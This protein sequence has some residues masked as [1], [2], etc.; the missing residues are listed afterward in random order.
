MKVVL[1]NTYDIQ[2]GAA[3]ATYRL[4]KGLRKYGVKSKLLVQYKRS[5]DFTV[6]GTQG[7]VER[8]LSYF[9]PYLDALVNRVYRNKKREL[10]SA[11]LVPDFLAKKITKLN[12]QIVHLFWVAGGFF[13]VETLKNIQVP[14]VWTL[15]DMWPFTGGCHYDDECGKFKNH[16]GNCPILNSGKDKDLS[17]LVLKRKLEAWDQVPIV[18]VATSYW[19]ADMAKASSVFKDKRVVVIPNGIDTDKYKPIDKAVSRQTWG[20]PLD[21]NL[22]L[23]SA[24]S[25]TSDKRKG[26]QFLVPALESMAREG[27]GENTELVIIGASEPEHPANLGMKV[28]YIGNLGDEISQILLYSAVDVTVAPSMQENLSNTVMESLACGAPVVA[29]NV[30]G[31]PDLIDHMSTGYLARPFEVDD[32]AAGIKWVVEDKNRHGLLSQAARKSVLEKYALEKVSN[33]YIDLYQDILK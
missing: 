17:H 32:L 5:D 33:Q 30:G 28:H 26:N 24:F 31:M 6:V 19:L 9:R 13:R 20:L 15:H 1:L 29:F 18:V 14:V 23:F 8:I 12:P 3:I 2:G 27:W 25:A 10:F 11:A 4:H 21:K 22:V 16:C 7:R